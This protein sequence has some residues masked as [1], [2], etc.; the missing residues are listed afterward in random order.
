MITETMF[1]AHG[2]DAIK[3]TPAQAK[4]DCGGCFGMLEMERA[5]QVIVER[6]RLA[7]TWKLAF[8]LNDFSQE[9]ELDGFLNLIQGQWITN[10]MLSPHGFFYV[11]PKFI[12]RVINGV[13]R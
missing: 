5:A 6:C 9:Y 3:T 8:S 13:K 2:L 1:M 7:E 11:T 4:L 10:H 12:E